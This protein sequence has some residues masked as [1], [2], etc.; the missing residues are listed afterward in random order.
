MKKQNYFIDEF[1]VETIYNQKCGSVKIA[2]FQA[3]QNNGKYIVTLRKGILDYPVKSYL[4]SYYSGKK[5][6]HYKEFE[7]KEDA[8]KY[9]NANK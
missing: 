8:N 9:I 1:L 5:N 4:Y 7:T 3:W 2:V 6:I